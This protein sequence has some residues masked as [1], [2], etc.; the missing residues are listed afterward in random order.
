MDD[1]R[2]MGRALLLA[3]RG[4][5]FVEPNPVVGAVVVKG[6]KVVGE[7]WHRFFG[8]PHAEVYAL[9]KAGAKARGAT[10]YVTLEPCCHWG[11]TPPCTDA[12]RAAGVK[13]VV[14]AMVDPF[15]K[16]RGKGLKILRG[17]GI[18]VECGCLEV[19]ARRVN[20]PFLMR[21]A[22]G[23][24]WVIAKWAQSLDGS[25]A[26]AGGESKWISGEGSRE[27]VQQLR[28]RVDGIVVGIGTVLA[29][30][31][32]LT[33]RP[34][35]ARDLRR[36]ATR[37]VLDRTCRLPLDGKL[38][39]TVGE[40]PVMVVHGEG[41]RGAAEARRK[42]LAERGAMT[43]GAKDVGRLL[44]YL[45]ERDYTNVLVEGGGRV[46]AA[47]FAGGWVDE[48][49]LFQAGL[50]IPGGRR[51]VA[52]EAAGRLA[53]APRLEI[54]GAERVGADVHITAYPERKGKRRKR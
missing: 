3:R 29:D 7:G 15:A 16:V 13:R 19:A 10:L 43:V 40:A 44:Q 4:A 39:R 36:V 11:K 26:T 14:V 52:G 25:I 33:A 41:L 35:R 1:E 18:E 5:G 30:D 37:M 31:P 48:C 9:Q 8:G 6:G 17:A 51:A 12:V 34:A 2:Y 42:K 28:G 23:R 54:A 46:L 27:I 21:V 49:H 45:G 50:L 22:E 47:F 20:G 24:P 32:L 53:E 38:M